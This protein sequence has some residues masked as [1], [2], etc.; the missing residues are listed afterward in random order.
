MKNTYFHGGLCITRKYSITAFLINRGSTDRSV[1][2]CKLL[3]PHWEVRNSRFLEFDPT[4]T[5]IEVMEIEREVSGWKIV[6]KYY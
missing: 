2:I 5:D 1:E 6:F 3:A 4:N